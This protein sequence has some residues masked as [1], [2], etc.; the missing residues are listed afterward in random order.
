MANDERQDRAWRVRP[1]EEAA[2]GLPLS[3]YARW[4]EATVDEKLRLARE[5]ASCPDFDAEDAF[6][7]GS[8]LERA[9]EEAGRYAE[10]E[11][12]LDVWKERA[13]RVYEEEPAVATGGRSWR[14]GCRAGT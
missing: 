2:A 9:L 3:F 1:E 12:V 13:A 14:C 7:V 4:E 8:R 6:E 10:L 11:S 5:A